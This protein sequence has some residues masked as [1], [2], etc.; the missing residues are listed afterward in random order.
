MLAESL[1]EAVY[2]SSFASSLRAFRLESISS[3]FIKSTIDVRHSSFS[4]LAATALSKIGATSTLAAGGIADEDPGVEFTVGAEP[5]P[6]GVASGAASALVP[7]IAPMIFPN[8]LILTSLGAA[9][10]LESSA[11][12]TCDQAIHYQHNDRANDCAYQ[13]G[14]LSGAIPTE[15]L[16]K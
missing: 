2:L 15:R 6:V 7:K 11:T 12:P 3:A 9:D 14:A 1:V 10:A 5:P 16:S 4:C 8:M 13:S